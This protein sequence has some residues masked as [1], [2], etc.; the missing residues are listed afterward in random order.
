MIMGRCGAATKAAM[1]GRRGRQ[2]EASGL[3][4]EGERAG[5]M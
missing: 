5:S 3:A 2:K 1:L 4:G